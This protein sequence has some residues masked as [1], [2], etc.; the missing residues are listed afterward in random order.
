MAKCEIVWRTI[1]LSFTWATSRNYV[2]SWVLGF[3]NHGTLFR[4]YRRGNSS[5]LNYNF[6]CDLNPI[7]H[8]LRFSISRQL[9]HRSWN[10]T[11]K[12]H[13]CQT[14]FQS[15]PILNV[16]RHRNISV[17]LVRLTQLHYK[18]VYQHRVSPGY[19]WWGNRTSC[20]FYSSRH[21][22]SVSLRFYQGTWDLRKSHLYQ[23]H[24]LLHD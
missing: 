3:R 12:R 16:S 9:L 8:C 6:K 10:R 7:F 18:N 15:C 17:Y 14:S 1:W 5:N 21:V 19:F 20:N 2:V 4:I 23:F 24:W 22:Q 13:S 11:R